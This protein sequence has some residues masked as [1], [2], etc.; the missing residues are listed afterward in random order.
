MIAERADIYMCLEASAE[1]APSDVLGAPLLQHCIQRPQFRR[2][3]RTDRHAR[4]DF[5][6]RVGKGPSRL[7]HFFFQVR[8]DGRGSVR[9]QGDLIDAHKQALILQH[10]GSGHFLRQALLRNR[11]TTRGRIA[12]HSSASI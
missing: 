5:G 12:T 1:T 2:E 4:Q 11:R 7:R 8:V 6:T 10:G 9:C 3:V